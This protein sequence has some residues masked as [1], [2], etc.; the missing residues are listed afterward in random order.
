MSRFVAKMHFHLFGKQF[1]KFLDAV[2]AGEIDEAFAAIALGQIDLEHVLKQGG[3]LVK[4]DPS[5]N[6]TGNRLFFSEPATEDHVVTFD[7][8]AALIHLCPEASRCRPYSAGRTNS[9][10]WS[11]EC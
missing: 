8:I 5:K 3:Q 4:G 2:A 7:R 11:D 9:G 10:N 6:F 1:L